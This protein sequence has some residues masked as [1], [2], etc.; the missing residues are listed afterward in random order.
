LENNIL[1]PR[2]MQ[3]VSG[4]SPLVILISVITFT[5]FFG[6]VGTLVAVPCVMV[7]Y[8]IVKRILNYAGS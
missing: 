2:I 1:V 7:G 8:V 4:F 3:K 5:N 6:L